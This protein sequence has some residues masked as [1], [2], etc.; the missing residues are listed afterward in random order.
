MRNIRSHL[1]L[2]SML[3]LML[4]SCSSNAPSTNNSSA[5]HGTPTHARQVVLTPQNTPAQAA[6]PTAISQQA[7]IQHIFYIMMENHAANQIIGNTADAPYLNQLASSYGTATQYYGVTHPSLPNYLAAISGSFQGIWDDCSAGADVTC[8]P[9]AF[10]SSL[11]SSEYTSATNQPHMFN[12]QTIVDQL[13]AHHMT[14]K[15]YMQ[16]M[17]SAGYTGES[18]AS[19]YAQ[20]HDPFMYFSSIRN[21]PTR[22]QQIVPFTQFALDMQSKTIPN[23]VWISPDVCNDMHG[24]PACSSYDG[25]IATGDNF[26]RSTVQ[27]IMHSPAW[28][29]GAAIVIT[30]DEND[31]GSAGCCK[32]PTG[33]NGTVL[34]GANVPLIVVT[35]YGSRHIVLNSMAYNHYSLLA[36]IE[37]IW[38]I[39][40]LAN[41]CG[42]NASSLLTPLFTQ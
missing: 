28:K 4:T 11:T 6:T 9:Q 42:M 41:T 20:K 24:A 18:Y 38:N 19:L 2:W 26:V 34:G 12:G 22:M 7:G 30:W 35:S 10:T 17:P 40:C 13:E 3:F 23:F 25:L 27:T 29:E 21:N 15:A 5:Q 37:H 1:L 33:A 32:S 16:S 36:T 14:W 31:E 39:G 8:A